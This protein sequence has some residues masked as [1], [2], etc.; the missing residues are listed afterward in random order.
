TNPVLS[1]TVFQVLDNQPSSNRTV[2]QELRLAGPSGNR[3]RWL[4]SG[5]YLESKQLLSTNIVR[6]AGNPVADPYNRAFL[7]V[8]NA[9]DNSRRDFGAGGQLDYDIL[10]QLTVSAG[11]RYD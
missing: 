5:D 2:T 8:S 3:L 1:P 10:Q 11:I 4:V 6:D 7:L 9:A